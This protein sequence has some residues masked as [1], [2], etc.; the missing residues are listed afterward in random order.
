MR[1]LVTPGQAARNRP[2]RRIR[3]MATV[4]DCDGSCP[5]A[6][7]VCLTLFRVPFS[8]TDARTEHPIYARATGVP[9]MH[10]LEGEIMLTSAIRRLREMWRRRRERIKRLNEVRSRPPDPGGMGPGSVSF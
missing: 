5:S 3:R 1:V 4:Y 9:L 8:G 6:E 10:F 2:G 7:A